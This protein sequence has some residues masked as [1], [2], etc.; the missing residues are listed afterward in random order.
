MS[1]LL[2]NGSFFIALASISCAG[3]TVLLA[4]CFR[5]KCSQINFCGI[6]CTRDIELENQGYEIELEHEPSPRTRDII[7][8]PVIPN[9]RRNST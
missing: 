3:F 9:S 5:L 6:L 1:D 7:P 4:H 8:L 2:S